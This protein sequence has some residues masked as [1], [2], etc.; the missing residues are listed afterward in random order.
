MRFWFFIAFMMQFKVSGTLDPRL[1]VD[2]V[3]EAFKMA[4][5]ASFKVKEPVKLAETKA[6]EDKVTAK[7]RKGP[8]EIS[9]DE[10]IGV[11]LTIN[12]TISI[13][14]IGEKLHHRLLG[15]NRN[16]LLHE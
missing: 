1:L 6:I 16:Q 7:P 13:M 4:S 5:A 14:T 8:R 9:L 11:A 10:K 2:A 12:N 15:F 3:Q